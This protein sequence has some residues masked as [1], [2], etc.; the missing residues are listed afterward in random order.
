M[1]NR[2]GAN[3]LKPK[4]LLVLVNPR[5]I[6]HSLA[7]IVKRQL[8]CKHG[9]FLHMPHRHMTQLLLIYGHVNSI[10]LAKQ[11]QTWDVHSKQTG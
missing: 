8:Y 4:V 5:A 1:H 3:S 9:P 11:K 7:H 2:K 6:N 10:W